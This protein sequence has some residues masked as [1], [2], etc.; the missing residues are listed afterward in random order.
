MSPKTHGAPSSGSA[1]DEALLRATQKL[2]AA[3]ARGSSGDL[4][5]AL[6]EEARAQWAHGDKDDAVMTVDEAISRTRRAFG[7]DDRHYAEALELGAEIA[8]GAGMPNAADARYRAALELLEGEGVTDTLLLSALHHHGTFRRDRGDL[9]AAMRAFVSVVERVGASG[10]REGLPFAAMSMTELGRI[11]LD[12]GKDG[13]ART[14]GDRALELWLELKQARRF[15]VADAM[16]LVGAAAL[17]QSDFEPAAAFLETACEIYGGCTVD[18]RAR[19][20]TAATGLAR[21]LEGLGKRE[22]ARR[23][24]ERALDLFREGDAARV[25]IEQRILELSRG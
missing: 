23:G 17:R 16:A 8:E 24:Y 25:E 22:E 5:L 3:R 10:E 7:P 20:A 11:A 6:I 18:V 21:A 4:A 9:E 19:N 1:E 13:E 14:L 15:E 12:E 2:E